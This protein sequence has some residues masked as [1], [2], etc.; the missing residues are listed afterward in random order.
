VLEIVPF[1]RLAMRAEKALPIPKPRFLNGFDGGGIELV[2]VKGITKDSP[3]RFNSIHLKPN[4]L[5]EFL[6]ESASGLI[7]KMQ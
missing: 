7:W 6:R 3:T 1:P 4:F 2:A 5:R